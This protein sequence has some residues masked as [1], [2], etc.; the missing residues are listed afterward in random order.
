MNKQAYMDCLTSECKKLGVTENCY[1]NTYTAPQITNQEKQKEF[2][3]NKL[4]KKKNCIAV[5]E[6][7]DKGKA[8]GWHFH[9]FSK[10]K[11]KEVTHT[12]VIYD[13]KGL[14]EYLSKQAFLI[15]EPIYVK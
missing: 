10:K 1:L 6:Y 13:L 14:I 3:L 15:N 7:D 11:Q 5:F 2:L 8:K 9:T 4:E 12:T